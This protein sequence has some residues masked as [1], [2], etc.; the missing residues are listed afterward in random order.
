MARR[1]SCS[2]FVDCVAYALCQL[3]MESVTLKEEQRSAMEAVYNGYDAFVWLPT[4][5]GKG[6]CYQ[7]LPFIMDFKLG[8][9]ESSKHSLVL[10]VSP[11]V[12][13]MVDQVT[14]RSVNC[15]IVTSSGGIDKEQQSSLFC[16]L[17][18]CTPEA[19][20][21]SRWRHSI[22]DAKVSRRIVSLVTEREIWTSNH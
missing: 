20:I 1:R 12:A 18:F 3:K 17:L 21:R 15:I 16:S 2:T 14:R 9:V 7:V 10:V 6:L 5:Y 13:L 22:E 19:L 4:G 8:L 11:L